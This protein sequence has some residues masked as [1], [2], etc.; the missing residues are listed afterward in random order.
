M[1]KKKTGRLCRVLRGCNYC[2]DVR[3]GFDST[4]S[5]KL[6]NT[7]CKH[8]RY[9]CW[10]YQKQRES[11]GAKVLPR[12]TLISAVAMFCISDVR[13]QELYN[14]VIFITTTLNHKW[15]T[16]EIEI[17][18][19]KLKKI[20]LF[21]FLWL[22]LQ[23]VLICAELTPRAPEFPI[24]WALPGVIYVGPCLGMHNRTCA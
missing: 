6:S 20:M 4:N 22:K 5:F 24:C 18:R 12:N 19:F 7:L 13:L 15:T 2:Y 23:F 1:Q 14:R 17:W 11:N 8:R 9:G 16:C 21:V 3:R 10:K